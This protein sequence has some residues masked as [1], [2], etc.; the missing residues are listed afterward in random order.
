M[1][2]HT[3]PQSRKDARKMRV[4]IF[5]LSA[6]ALGLG[7]VGGAVVQAAPASADTPRPVSSSTAPASSDM[8]GLPGLDMSGMA[9]SGTATKAR[10]NTDWSARIRRA[11]HT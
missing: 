5:A 10:S 4:P 8:A 2:T 1:W 11:E 9:S 6:L 3:A 7:L